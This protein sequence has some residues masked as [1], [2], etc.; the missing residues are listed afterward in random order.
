MK[1]PGWIVPLMIVAFTLAGLGGAE[2]FA[3]PSVIV[4]YPEDRADRGGEMRTVTLL[5]EGVKCVDTARSAARTLEGEEG[6]IRFTAYASR[7]RVEV[8][9]DAGKTTVQGIVEA[10]E[11][12]VFEKE[13]GEFHF[14]LYRVV[15]ID[16]AGISE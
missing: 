8:L 2:L 11:G 16:G 13:T 12:P 9:F 10:L 6:V 3:I 5:V 4:D 14:G 1:I 15:E 7:N